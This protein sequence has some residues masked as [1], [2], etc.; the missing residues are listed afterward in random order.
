MAP[1][2]LSARGRGLVHGLDCT[3]GELASRACMTAFEQGLV[4]ERSGADDH[5]IKCICPLTITDAE[6]ERGL[7]VL[8]QSVAA[9]VAGPPATAA[10]GGAR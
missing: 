7:D 4:I 9:T 3:S 2:L 6:L 1:E 10:A 5:V 8:R